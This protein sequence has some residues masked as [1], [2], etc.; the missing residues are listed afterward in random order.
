MPSVSL[1]IACSSLPSG[2]EWRH[3]LSSRLPSTIAGHPL[4]VT[5]NRLHAPAK[6]TPVGVS[7][8]PELAPLPT[9]LSGKLIDFLVNIHLALL[10]SCR[11]QVLF[12]TT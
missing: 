11:C 6:K 5:V 12:P 3:V 4:H 9:D 2:G 1:H 8:K 7:A 10:L